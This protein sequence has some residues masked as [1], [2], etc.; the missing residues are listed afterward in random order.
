MN[1]NLMTQLV[2]SL[3]QISPSKSELGAL[4]ATGLLKPI[5]T[6]DEILK[7]QDVLMAAHQN[8]TE[9]IEA[10]QEAVRKCQQLPAVPLTKHVPLGF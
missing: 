6:L 7:Y 10:T 3:K 8:D 1:Q 4:E 9:K 5:M 2:S